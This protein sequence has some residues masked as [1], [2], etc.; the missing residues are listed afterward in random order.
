MAGFDRL[1]GRIAADG[2]LISGLLF[3]A[4]SS[5][6]Q[7]GISQGPDVLTHTLEAECNAG[8][9]RLQYSEN[10]DFD[11]KESPRKVML[12]AAMGADGH[13]IAASAEVA[14]A[15]DRMAWVADLSMICG[16]SELTVVIDFVDRALFEQVTL[17]D[18][19]IL[20]SDLPHKRAWMVIRNGALDIAAQE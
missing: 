16:A 12:V 10:R 18:G 1:C 7:A 4:L 13:A 3:A 11:R 9:Y 14:A 6:V 20:A 17:R 8:T 5:P 19:L 2:A 15:F